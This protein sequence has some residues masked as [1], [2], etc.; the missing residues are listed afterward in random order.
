MAPNSI[1][2]EPKI[3]EEKTTDVKPKKQVKIKEEPIRF[4]KSPTSKDRIQKRPI[5]PITPNEKILKHPPNLKSIDNLNINRFIIPTKDELSEEETPTKASGSKRHNVDH[6][7]KGK[8]SE[9][10]SNKRHKQ[11]QHTSHQQSIT[12]KP[13]SIP[14]KISA[15]SVTPQSVGKK[16]SSPLIM[17]EPYKPIT[18]PPK[19]QSFEES[20]ILNDP[21]DDINFDKLF[22]NV[23][24]EVQKGKYIDYGSKS[25]DDW[26]ETGIK[27]T[28]IQ[29]GIV[30]KVITSR[31]KLNLKF[32]MILK[33]INKNGES[34]EKEDVVLKEKMK[35]LQ[36]LG[37][38]IRN[39]IK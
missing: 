5:I 12:P 21:K 24:D 18:K 17:N 15:S 30:K 23:D 32:G 4:G 2:Q 13:S 25:F 28:N 9:G 8:E 20:I 34:L 19:F 16:Q 27:L 3:K 26:C 31:N 33:L 29:Y 6:L 38:E 7:G 1:I 35:R 36:N 22:Q 39:F 14:Q 37:E 11:Q 10:I